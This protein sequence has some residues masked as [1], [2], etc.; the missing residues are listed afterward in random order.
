M[1]ILYMNQG[2]KGGWG[3][4][5]YSSYDIVCLAESDQEKSGFSLGWK[6]T[7]SDPV[8]SVQEKEGKRTIINPKD[9]DTLCETVRPMVT[10]TLRSSPVRVVFVHLKSASEKLATEAFKLAA[11]EVEKLS[12]SLSTSPVIWIGDF[13]RADSI[14]GDVCDNTKCLHAGGGYSK[15]DLDRVYISGKWKSEPAVDV[16]STSSSDHGHQGLSVEL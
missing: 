4:I 11:K 13:N 9:L 12:G 3:A 6:S 16:V 5:K 10:F 7:D 14:L 2:V 8:M 15:W 1:K